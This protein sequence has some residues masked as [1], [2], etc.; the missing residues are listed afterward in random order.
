MA[1]QGIKQTP[2]GNPPGVFFMGNFMGNFVVKT[3]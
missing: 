3:L 2:P 1:G